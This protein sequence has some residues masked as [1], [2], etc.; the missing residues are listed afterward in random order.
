MSEKCIRLKYVSALIG[1]TITL[2]LL[3]SISLF[4]FSGNID[5]FSDHFTLTFQGEGDISKQCYVCDSMNGIQ[6]QQHLR[7][8]PGPSSHE[9]FIHN[10]KMSFMN[11]VQHSPSWIL[12]DSNSS[13]IEYRAKSL[14]DKAQTLDGCLHCLGCR[15][16]IE[17]CK[18]GVLLPQCLVS[19]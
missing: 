16:V 11:T 3:V 6:C 2:P 12:E 4:S 9:I 5:R 10:S 15:A 17:V 1:K 14:R 7:L 19:W 13:T 8:D 18:N